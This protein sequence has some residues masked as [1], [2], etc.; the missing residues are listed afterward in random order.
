[1][2]KNETFEMHVC[3][4]CEG[5]CCHEGLYVTKKEY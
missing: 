1:M 5:K 4:K 3:Q 2:I